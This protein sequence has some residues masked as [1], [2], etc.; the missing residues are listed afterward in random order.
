[1]PTTILPK[2]S[3]LRLVVLNDSAPV[4][5]ML[6]K[7]LQD[8]GHHCETA[9]LADMPQAQDQVGPFIRKHKPDVVI[10]DVGM[11]YSSSW[12]LLE[13]IRS[14]PAL[15][16]QPFVITTPNKRKLEQAVGPTSAFEIGG[17]DSELRRVLKAV[18]A[19]ARD[20]RDES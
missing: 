18:E 6:C 7:W 5:K 19:A 12:D 11:P 16:S 17:R 2:R 14:A 10:Y 3:R 13:V 15:Q 4:L 8:H 20:R 9:L 1:M